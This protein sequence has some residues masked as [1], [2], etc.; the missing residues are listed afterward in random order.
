MCW[1]SQETPTNVQV[2]T[3]ASKQGLGQAAG[4]CQGHPHP[5]SPRAPGSSGLDTPRNSS[6]HRHTNTGQ[7]EWALFWKI[8][9]AHIHLYISKHSIRNWT[10]PLS[11]ALK[12]SGPEHRPLFSFGVG[13]PLPLLLQHTI[14]L[15]TLGQILHW[16]MASALWGTDLQH[17]SRAEHMGS[18]HVPPHTGPAPVSSSAGQ[19]W[20][21]YT[22][23]WQQIW[24]QDT[25]G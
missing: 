23:H 16:F 24:A 2:L 6:Q 18:L 7:T 12:Y 8:N 15:S 13:I 1:E 3:R 22:P 14:W 20:G 10:L 25:P 21:I 4:T 19:G 17:K 11:Q 9:I 5:Q